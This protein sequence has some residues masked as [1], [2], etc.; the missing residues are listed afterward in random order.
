M[1]VLNIEFLA[2]NSINIIFLI[3]TS[4][5]VLLC[6]VYNSEIHIYNINYINNLFIVLE[7]FL[8]LLFSV[9]DILLFFI[10][11]EATL[12]PLVII[13]N[14]WGSRQRKIHSM[15]YLFI[16]TLVGS[17]FFLIGLLK[18]NIILGSFNINLIQSQVINFYDQIILFLCFFISFSIKVPL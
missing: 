16:Y 1:S 11:F 7:M 8:L 9:S 4:L 5:L 15:Y 17:I 14:V 6:V 3:L 10:F 2:I 12:I 18:L 13:I